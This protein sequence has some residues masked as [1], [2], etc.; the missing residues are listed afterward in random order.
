VASEDPQ[1]TFDMLLDRLPWSFA[2]IRFPW[3]AYPLHV[4]GANR[5]LRTKMND[6]ADCLERE[7][8]WFM[9]VCDT[10]FEAYFKSDHAGADL[11]ALAPPP[12]VSAPAVRMPGARVPHGLST[13][14]WY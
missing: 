11:A 10:R 4:T 14:A 8:T 7:V 6:I 12:D 5:C 9:Q 2:M 3:M 1:A 13:S